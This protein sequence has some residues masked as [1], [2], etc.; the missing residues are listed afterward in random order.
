MSNAVAGIGARSNAVERNRDRSKT[1]DAVAYSP[2]H[3]LSRAQFDAVKCS[4]TQLRAFK[5]SQTQSTG[6][7]AGIAVHEVERARRSRT[8]TNAVQLARE[9]SRTHLLLVEQS[10][11]HAN[12][13]Q[14]H[15]N[16]VKCTWTQSTSVAHARSRTPTNVVGRSAESRVDERRRA[17]SRGLEHRQIW[18]NCVQLCAIKTVEC[19]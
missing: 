1:V 14:T 2:A 19:C 7:N 18:Q 16:R 10:V 3:S 6:P 8:Q 11:A 15:S 9:R 12:Y 4:R 13:S 17:Q 5:R